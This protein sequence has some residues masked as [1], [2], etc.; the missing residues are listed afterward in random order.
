MKPPRKNSL[1]YD[2]LHETPNH[3]LNLHVSLWNLRVSLCK[4][5]LDYANLHETPI[6]I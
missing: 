4:N 2:N 6:H 5:S 1:D 3:I